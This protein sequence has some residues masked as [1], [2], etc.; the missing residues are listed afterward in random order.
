MLK[1]FVAESWLVLVLAVGFGLAMAQ[2][3]ASLKDEIA[4]NELEELKAAVRS[5][6][7]GVKDIR[8]QKVT[9][10]DKGKTGEV[11]VYRGLDANNRCVGYAVPA[12]GQGFQGRIRVV[13]GLDA[14]GAT[15]TGLAIMAPEETP[16]LGSRVQDESFRKGRFQGHTARQNLQLIKESVPVTQPDVQVQAVTGA[17]ISSESVVTIV[18]KRLGR[19]RDWLAK[20]E[21]GPNAS[22]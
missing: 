9:Y 3:Y 12:E 6:I 13:I 17:T 21:G 2:T 19:I 22:R 14:A 20:Q 10:T 8:D 16:G 15:I 5:V 1:K 11:V 4:K 18:N 7:P